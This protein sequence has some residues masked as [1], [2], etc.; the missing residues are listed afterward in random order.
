MTSCPNTHNNGAEKGEGRKE[1]RRHNRIVL[2]TYFH[3]LLIFPSHCRTTKVNTEQPLCARSFLRKNETGSN[4]FHYRAFK[5]PRRDFDL[6][7][8]LEGVKAFFPHLGISE[9]SILKGITR[10]TADGYKWR[11]WSLNPFPHPAA[12]YI[13]RDTLETVPF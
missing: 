1:G 12:S 11:L 6:M 8:F 13:K 4:H 5:I 7:Q 10:F 9:R 3:F 2:S